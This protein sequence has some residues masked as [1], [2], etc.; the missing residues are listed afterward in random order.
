MYKKNLRPAIAM[1]EL[2]FALVIMGIVLMSAPM[3]ISM[4][5]K[6][7]FVAIQQEAI[8]EAASHVN[9][10]MGYHWDEQNTDE[11]YLDTILRTNGN[12]DLNESANTKRRLGTP[13][14]TYRSFIRRDGVNN[15]EATA[16]AALGS[17]G[18]ETE[19]ND[20]DDFSGKTIN[21][22]LIDSEAGNVETT[23]IDIDTVVT[24]NNDG[25]GGGYNPA[26][27]II[28]FNP[29]TAATTN[30]NIKMITTT[31]TSSSGVSELNK[32]IVFRAFSC[33][34]GSFKLKEGDF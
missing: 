17:D 3:L 24:Y 30:T 9:M 19:E 31:L 18:T 1:I 14:I 6:S 27:G 22:T 4:A 23:T 8:N 7:S 15:L 25:V 5:A 34:I 33:N 21:L 11:R 16:P 29:F 26:T 20:I 12:V 10:V 32:S 28:T 2:I 13:I